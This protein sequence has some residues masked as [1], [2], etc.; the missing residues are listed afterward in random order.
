M[1]KVTPE[2]LA[3][4]ILENGT[5]Y[6]QGSHERFQKLEK[7]LKNFLIGKAFYKKDKDKFKI[8]YK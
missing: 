7:L 8:I 2:I 3:L 1:K 5:F 6:N 4:I